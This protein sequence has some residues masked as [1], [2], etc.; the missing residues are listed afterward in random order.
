[1]CYIHFFSKAV[2][3]KFTNVYDLNLKLISIVI[4]RFLEKSLE[5]ATALEKNEYN[6]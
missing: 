6:T 1:M 3:T 2:A 4:F 5:G